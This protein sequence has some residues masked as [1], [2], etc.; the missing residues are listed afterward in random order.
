[1]PGEL[2]F[3]V[4]GSSA[5]PAV[6]VTL[7]DAGLRER[8][9]LQEWV[10]A[11][12]EILGSDVMVV[13]FEFDRWKAGATGERERDRLDVLGLDGDGRLVVAELK[14]DRAPDTVN[15]QAIKYAAMASRFTEESLVEHYVDFRTRAGEVVDDDT[16]RA[17]LVAHAG[18]LDAEQL[19]RPR[20]VLVAGAFPPV[21]TASAVWLNEMGLD[22]TMQRVQAYRVFD[23]RVVVTVSQ[24]FPVPDVEEF[25]VSPQRAQAQAVEDR[26]RRGREKSTVQK[27]VASRVI[28][29]G[30]ELVLRPTTEI[31]KDLRDRL[32]AW[33]AE[34]PRRGRARWFNR[35]RD[36][37][38][39][40]YDGQ[41]YRPSPLVS[42]MLSEAA[43][44]SR[45]VRGPSW[46][47]LPDGRDLPTAAGGVRQSAGFD[48]SELHAAMEAVPRGRWTTYGDLARVIGT[49][50]QPLGQHIAGCPDC[51]NAQR[52]LGADGRVRPGFA[53]S[54]PTE[55][56]TAEQVLVSEGVRVDGGVADRA[57]RL[58][59]DD[60]ADL[61]QAGGD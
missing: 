21:V 19:R 6:P 39:W 1:M 34:D 42:T 13:A 5:T 4:E 22:I 20:I 12:P 11:H 53:W 45:S 51:P 61:V 8:N 3:T 43:Q 25:T 57:Q 40:V 15:M 26:R 59:V 32:L 16:A 60:L 2:V 37:L 24:L 27:L 31:D 10:L 33:V 18:E 36:P 35:R 23:D 54:D 49:A 55:T 44:V 17:A 29:D 56:R 50:A 46:W 9:D 52:V 38:E 7:A 30:T 41:T 48:W 58:H 14:R 47:V 28:D